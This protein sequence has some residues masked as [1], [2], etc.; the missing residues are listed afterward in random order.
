MRRILAAF[1]VALA[2]VLLAGLSQSGTDMLR[3]ERAAAT[4][5]DRPVTR[6]AGADTVSFGLRTVSFN[7]AGGQYS[8][9]ATTTL[10]QVATKIDAFQ[11]HLVMLQ[12]V[13]WS[14]YEWLRTRYAG[15][16]DFGYTPLISTYTGCGV[17]DCSVNADSDPSNDDKR[18]WIGQ[19]LGGRGA[20][21]NRDE[22][23]LG[24]ERH[25]INQ[26]DGGPVTQVKP[27]R[28]FTALCYDVAL[29]DLPDRTVKGCSV[30][31]RAFADDALINLRARTAQAARLASDLDGDI[32]AHKIV[33]VGGDFN[34][35]PENGNSRVPRRNPT[36]NAFYRPETQP[37]GGWGVFYEA[38]QAD[39]RFWQFPDERPCVAST[40]VAS[41]CRS[42]ERTVTD[43]DFVEAEAPG[44]AAVE[45]TKY[46]YIF[47]SELTGPTKIS[48]DPFYLFVKD[49]AGN[50][51]KNPDGTD[52]RVSDHAFYQAVGQVSPTVTP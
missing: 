44:E 14:Q 7:M 30:H 47:Y 49:A 25:Q 39:Q 1:A 41:G 26:A 45:G 20:L 19:V 40:T 27:E 43:D 29:A 35:T 52:K 21:S 31:L 24:G 13:C 16:Y 8:H 38:D 36:M 51:V 18:C 33:V 32:A 48:G 4:D 11:P 3:S 37:G 23:A 46:D 15:T 2:V 50:N 5:T 6:T 9:G 42:G 10:P 17:N 22:V 34:S 12:E 28:K